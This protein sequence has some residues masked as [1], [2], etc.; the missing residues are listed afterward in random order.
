MSERTSQWY[1]HM[2]NILTA[3]YSDEPTGWRRDDRFTHRLMKPSTSGPVQAITWCG[4]RVH[5]IP[6]RGEIDCPKCLEA[7]RE[8]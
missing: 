2:G 8:E 5:E 6:G 4:L 3:P 1:D 7:I